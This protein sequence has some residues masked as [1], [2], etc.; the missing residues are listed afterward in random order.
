MESQTIVE[1]LFLGLLEGL[2]EFIP[3]SSTGHL[4]LA[5]H[6]LGFESNGK[7]FEVLI[8][9]GAIL[10][11]LTVYFSRLVNIARDIPVDPKTRRFV[12]GVLVAFLP[13]VVIGV[14]AHGFI[15]TVLFETPM[16]I[17]VMLIIGGL[18]LLW[19]DRL[20][21]KPRYT[22]VMEYPLSLCFK[23]G[24]IQ[25]FA[26]IPGTSRSGA[27]IV[28]ALLLGT[29]KR[30]AAEFSFFLAMPTMAGAFAYDLYQNRHILTFNDASLIVVGFIAAFFAGVFVVRY[31]LDY[32]SRHGFGLFAWWRLV[33][34]TVGLIALILMR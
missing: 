28:G 18:I 26:M 5:G 9:L 30:S 20:D 13:A 10:A 32:V 23:I 16:L 4:L 24:L 22:N 3:V 7:T 27:T 15:K 11:I 19:V 6:F 25:C 34:G 17:C 21:L 8:Q 31:L 1:A 14:M 29:D 33:V 2:T 12:L